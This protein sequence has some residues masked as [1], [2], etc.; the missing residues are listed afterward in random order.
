MLFVSHDLG[1]VAQLCPRTIWLAAGKV[2]ADG[3]TEHVISAY[4]Q[5]ERIRRGDPF[6]IQ[7]GLTTRNTVVGLDAALYVEDSRG[8]RVLDEAL[9]ETLGLDANLSEPGEYR[10]ALDV[11]APLAAKEYV[12]GVWL[13]TRSDLLRRRRPA[14]RGPACVGGWPG[15][16]EVPRASRNR[17]LADDIGVSA[18]F[19]PSARLSA[20][21]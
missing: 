3:A 14:F 21:S 19:A 1:S 9:S 10:L 4:Q 17:T 8:A 2:H 12:I 15:S 16:D 6:V 5:L 20:C 18:S 11:P 7:I 13:G